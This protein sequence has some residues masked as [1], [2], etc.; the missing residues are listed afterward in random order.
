[1]KITKR[2]LQRIIK[3]N[4]TMD[5]DVYEA[6]YRDAMQ[7]RPHGSN[8]DMRDLDPRAY[9][10]GFDTGTAD[11][12]DMQRPLGTE[13]F[14]E[15]AGK[16]YRNGEATDEEREAVESILNEMWERGLTNDDLKAFLREVIR[17]IDRGYVGDR[18]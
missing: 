7:D 8:P 18:L 16:L 11:R 3:E 9:D 14:F 4:V 5:D 12:M 6:G 10:H 1:M 13:S 2:Q 15:A 17:D